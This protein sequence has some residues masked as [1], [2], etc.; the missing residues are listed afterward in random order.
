MVATKNGGPVDIHKASFS[1]TCSSF[2]EY[3]ISC[4][5]R[6]LLTLLSRLKTYRLLT[7]V[8]WLTLTMSK[9]SP[10]LFWS[11]F[12][13]SISGQSVGKMVWRTFTSIHGSSTARHT[14]PGS[15][16]ASKD[17]LSGREAKTSTKAHKTRPTIRWETSK[18]SLSTW[19]SPWTER[20]TKEEA[21]VSTL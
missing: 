8:C 3:I 19:S 21:A 10:M 1:Y 9:Q 12:Q 16:V 18:T 5:D 15:R 14:Y 7:M 20:R 11:L 6:K 13:T 17:S 2:T 4:S